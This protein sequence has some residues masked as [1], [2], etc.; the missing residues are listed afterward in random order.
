V[1]H[2]PLDGQQNPLSSV[3]L[4]GGYDIPAPD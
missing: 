3:Y 1:S 4:R 2:A